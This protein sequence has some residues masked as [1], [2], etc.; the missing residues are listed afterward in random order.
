MSWRDPLLWLEALVRAALWR[1]ESRLA[2]VTLAALALLIA[3]AAIWW[4]S[5][6]EVRNFGLIAAAVIAL[7]LAIW[8]SRVSE[9]QAET[10][11][12]AQ[13]DE[14]YH[15]AVG[16]LESADESVR[17]TAARTL[18]QLA[19]AYPEEYELQVAPTTQDRQVRTGR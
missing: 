17:E 7:P 5:S 15:R 13:L 10:A 1:L 11:H 6:D 18:Q 14:R 8:R 12:R 3:V 16:M 4:D 2:L 19:S 9:R